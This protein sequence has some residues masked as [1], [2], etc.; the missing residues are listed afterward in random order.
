MSLDVRKLGALCHQ[1]FIHQTGRLSYVISC[2]I[3]LLFSNAHTTMI[4]EHKN[5]I[6]RKSDT[7]ILLVESL[8]IDSVQSYFFFHHIGCSIEFRL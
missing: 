5:I 4:D 3:S 6:S 7:I 1:V 2:A 8:L